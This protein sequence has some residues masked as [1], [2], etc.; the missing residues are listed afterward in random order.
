M[1]TKSLSKLLAALLLLTIL[2][3]CAP[4]PSSA[5]PAAEAT[6]APDPTEVP[7]E[8]PADQQADASTE[9][10]TSSDASLPTGL[11]TY[12]IV[13]EESSASYQ[14]DEE[15]FGL[16]LGKYGIPAGL[17]DTVGTTQAIEGQFQLNWDDLTAPLGENTFTVDLS[18]LQ[19]NQSLRDSWIRE[20]G[21]EFDTYPTATF[22][23]E[24]LEGAPTSY[25]LGEEV[26]FQMV[27]QL[28]IHET[29][30]PATFDI[31]AK[32]ED[33]TITGTA[34]TALKMTDFGITPPDF[35]NTLTVADDFVV[36]LEFTAR[37]Q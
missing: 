20:N 36:N 26:S 1:L 12:V 14:V 5:P 24:S 25:T 16:A 8:T 22:V 13:P 10:D 30:Q 32:L 4:A 3:A 21:P 17:S 7:A 37:E 29:T 15:F 9:E 27:G 18:T 35:A 34:T 31:T 2:T 19:S 23:A 11:R 6:S 28:T 33:G